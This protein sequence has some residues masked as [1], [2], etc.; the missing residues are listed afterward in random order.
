MNIIKNIKDL[1][2]DLLLNKNTGTLAWIMHRVTGLLLTLYI[3]MHLC[4]LGSELWWGAG[5]FDALM[6][7]FHK[8]VFK[9]MEFCLIGVIGYHIINGI[10]IILADFLIKTRGQKKLFWLFMVI[11]AAG[12]IFTLIFFVQDIL[13]K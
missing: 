7:N 10:R 8:P 9:A 5:A 4:V 1:K 2:N 12:M 11:L 3:F 13:N 6:G